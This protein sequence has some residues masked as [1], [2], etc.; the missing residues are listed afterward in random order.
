MEDDTVIASAENEIESEL[1]EHPTDFSFFQAVRILERLR[2]RSANGSDDELSQAVRFSVNP[3]TSFPA[4][5]IQSLESSGSGAPQLLVNFFGLTGPQG[6]LPYWYTHFVAERLR[7]RDG[8][9]QDFLDIFHNRIISH[10]HRAWLKM[11]PHVEF[12][13][14]G[15]DRLS[16][17]V[18]GLVGLGTPG[19][20]RRRDIGDET[21]MFYAALFANHHRSAIGL[22]QLLS[23]Y[24]GVQAQ[25]EQLMGG[26]YVLK[27][28]EQCRLGDDWGLPNALGDG[29]V[30]G[31][32]VW[33]PQL[34]AR[35]RLGPLTREQYDRFLPGRSAHVELQELTRFYSDDE[36]EFEL[37]LILRQ[38]DIPPIVLDGT[39]ATALGWTT[40]L[41]TTPATRD[42]DDAVL[43]L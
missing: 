12:E 26:W 23:D 10:F 6:V 30:V 19:L 17:L 22:E 1:F 4:S 13:R 39:G 27:D 36:V 2:V 21:M 3:S 16:K 32:E 9:M 38:R 14:S 42:A 28:A 25:V 31:D 34:K 18:L 33:D 24:F 20:A 35:I 5:E 41:M 43:S 29:A 40:W 37:Q 8:A 7:A 15:T 11:R